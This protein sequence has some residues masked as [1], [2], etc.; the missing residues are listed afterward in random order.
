MKFNIMVTTISLIL[1]LPF[2]KPAIAPI[3]APPRAA[4]TNGLVTETPD[5]GW[6]DEFVGLMIAVNE[7]MRSQGLAD[8]YPFVITDATAAKIDFVHEAVGRFTNRPVEP[9]P[10]AS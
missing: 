6:K 3:T 7:V 10:A 2:K 9:L 8:A 4:A 1:N 5:A